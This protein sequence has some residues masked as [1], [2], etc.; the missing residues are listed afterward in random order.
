[1]LHPLLLLG[2]Q[3]ETEKQGQ[4]T[5]C[6]SI[7]V[8]TQVPQYMLLPDINDSSTKRSYIVVDA[9]KK[10]KP[11]MNDAHNNQNQSAADSIHQSPFRAITLL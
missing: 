7:F 3:E 5:C 11:L 8:V 9:V 4:F 1:M 2:R 6:Q 10:K